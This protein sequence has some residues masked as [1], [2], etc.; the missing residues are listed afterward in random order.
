MSSPGFS[1]TIRS[2]LIATLVTGGFLLAPMVRHW[3]DRTRKSGRGAH[4]DPHVLVALRHAERFPRFI[5][6]PRPDGLSPTGGVR[7]S[8]PERGRRDRLVQTPFAWIEL[9]GAEDLLSRLPRDLRDHPGAEVET[10]AGR[11]TPGVNILQID[12]RSLKELGYGRI[13]SAIRSAGGRVLRAAPSRALIVRAD[14][15]QAL[16]ALGG[17]P[18]VEAAGAYRAAYKFSP[19]VGTRPL[20]SPERAGRRTM[21][22]H[23]QLWPGGDADQAA[24]RMKSVAGA[25]NVLRASLDGST[26][27]IRANRKQLIDLARLPAVAAIREAP[28]F[29][30]ANTEAPPTVM[31]G[32]VRDSLRFSRPYHDVGV[33][34]GGIDTNGDGRR[35]NDGSDA[36]P[37]QI[38]AVTD[39]GLSVD[40]TQFSQ[41][42]TQTITLANPIGPSHRKIHFI[43]NVADISLSACDAILSGATTHGNVVAGLIAGNPGELGFAY[44]KQIDPQEMPLV[45]NLSLDALARGARILMQDAASPG[46]CTLNEL[47]ENGGNVQPGFLIDRLTLAICPIGGGTG[48][49]EGVIG[50][51]EDLHLHVMPFGVPNFD[52]IVFN[53]ANGTYTLEA[54]QID[55]FLVN[56][57]DYMVFVPVGNQGNRPGEGRF[58]FSPTLWPDL[59]NGTAAD[60][61]PNLDIQPLQ[62]SPPATAKNIVSVGTT[63][64]DSGTFFEGEEDV[65]AYSAHGPAT[66]ASLRT[67]PIVMAQGDDFTGFFGAPYFQSI[68]VI[69][70]RDNDQN[71]PVQNEVDDQNFGTSFSAALATAA[72]ALVRDYFAQG[73]YP[74]AARD[75]ADRMP[76]ISGSLVRAAL[77]AS[78]NFSDSTNDFPVPERVQDTDRILA[79]TRAANLGT[80]AGIPVGIMGNG[81][82]GYG[83]I[84]LDQVLPL[85]NYPPTRGL[86][87]TGNQIEYPAPGLLVYDYLGTG[88]PPIDNSGNSVVEKMFRVDGVNAVM[89]GG[90]RA[91]ANGQLRI[92]LSWPDPPDPTGGGVLI[93]DL[94]LEVESPGPDNCLTAS[95]TKP[96]GSPCPANAAD[97]NRAYDGNVYISGRG[98][99]AGQWSLER[100]V[101]ET[102]IHDDKNNIEAVHLSSLVDDAT[103]NQLVAGTWRVRVK[104]GAAGV[105]PGQIVLID[106]SN[107]DTDGNGRLDPDEVDQDGDGLLD[108]GGQPFSLVVAG[109]VFGMGGQTWNGKTH[110]LPASIIAL[111]KFKYGCSDDLRT[112]VFDT[113]GTTGAGDVTSN[114]LLRVLDRSGAVQDEERLSF[115]AEGGGLFGT[116]RTPVRLARPAI[117]FNGIVEGDDDLALVVTYTDTP[118]SAVARAR[119]EC[120]PNIIRSEL[121]ILGITNPEAFIGGGC[122]GD[123]FLDAGER[124]TYSVAL[125]N[126]EQEDDFTE[127]VATLTPRGPGAAA[128]RVLDSPKP[129]GR[130][131]GGQSTGVTF[132]LEVDAGVVS[133]LSL[134]ERRVDLVLALEGGAQNLDLSRATYTFSHVINSDREVLHYSTDFPDGG[135]EIRDFNRNL[136]IDRADTFDPFKQL[137]WPDEAITFQSMFVPGTAT[138][139]IT[140]TLGEDLNDNGVLDAGEDVFANGALDRGILADSGGPSAGDLVP[141]SFDRNDGGWKA[142]RSPLSVPGGLGASPLWEHRTEGLCGFQTAAGL[143]GTLGIWHTGDGDPSTPGPQASACDNYR[144]PQD[145]STPPLAE[146]ILDVLHSPIIAKVHQIDDARG[147][148]FE[149]EFQRLGFNMNIQTLDYAGGHVDLDTDIE[150]DD[151]NCLLCNYTYGNFR[152]PDIY[153]LAVFNQYYQGI[154]PASLVNQRTF[155]PL[156]DPDGSILQNRTFDGDESGFSAFT[157]DSNPESTSPIP[158]APPDFHPFP[159]PGAPQVC[160]DACDPATDPGCECEQNTDAGPGR[161]FDLV[162]LEMRDGFI[163]MSLGGGQGEPMGAHDFGPVGNRWQIG[164]GFWAQ[165]T[166]AGGT[167]Y[168]IGIDDVVLE[169]DEVHPV[170]EGTDRA[171]DRFGG[172]GQPAG[173]QCATLVVDRLNIYECNDT[174]EV[175]VN[176]PNRAGQ[177]STTVLATT[178]SDGRPFSTG[179]TTALIPVKSFQ[180]PEV[181]NTGVFRGNVTIGTLFNNDN[182]LFTNPETDAVLNFFYIDPRCD[183]DADGQVGESEFGNI[184]NDGID[185]GDNCPLL[186]NPGQVDQDLDGAGDL[187]D[188]CPSVANPDQLDSD[189]DRVGDVCDLDDIDFDGVVNDLDNCPDVFNAGQ[190]PVAGQTTR[191]LACFQTSDRDGDGVNDRNDNCVRTPNADQSDTD[192]DRIGD[193]CDG[194]CVNARAEVLPTGSCNRTSDT[195]CTADA[196]CP[197][198]GTCAETPGQL[199]TSSTPQCTCENLS[200]ESCERLGVANDGGCGTVQDDVDGDSVTDAIDNCPTIPNPSPVPGTT[201]QSDLDSD[202]R[203]DECDPQG[204]VDD[205]NNGIP[206]DVISFN[207]VVACKKLPLASFVVLSTSVRDID[208]DGDLFADT[209]ETARMSL[210]VRNTGPDLTG[211]DLILGTEDPDISCITR[212]T[213]SVPALPSGAVLETA[214]LGEAGEFEF[215]VNPLTETINPANAERGT[216]FLTVSANEAVGTSSKVTVEILLD[217]DVAGGAP[218]PRVP[219]PDGLSGTSD[220]GF[221][222]ENFDTDREGNDG[223]VSLSSLPIGTPNSLNDTIGVTVGTAQGG[224]NSIDAVGC[225]GFLVPPEDP[226][227]RIDPDNDMDW[228]IHCPAGS[229]DGGALFV[230]PVGG[231]LAASAPNSLHWGVHFD[232]GNVNGDTVHHRELAAF[233]TNPINL[234]L[235]P[236]PGELELSFFM[237]ASMMDDRNVNDFPGQANDFGDVQI[238][239]DLNP[240]PG[241]END[242][243]GFWEKL[244]P[245]E[246]TYDHIAY[247]WSTFGTSPTY[248]NL[249]PTD[250][251]P[252]A[253]APRGIRETLCFPLGIWSACGNAY[254]DDPSFSVCDGTVTRQNVFGK[255]FFV[256]TKFSLANFLGQ[257]VRIRWIAQGWEFDCCSSSY[258]ETGGT[259]ADFPGDDGWWIDDIQLTGAIESQFTP[260]ADMDPPAQGACP[261]D[262]CDETAGDG[263]FLVD[264]AVSDFDGDGLFVAGEQAT[265]SA[266]GT[267]PVGGCVGGGTQ[268]RFFKGEVPVQDW[269]STPTFVDHPLRPTTYRAQ[270]RCSVDP[271][272]TSSASATGFNTASILVYSGDADEIALSALHDRS[273]GVTTIEWQSVFQPL[274]LTGY[275]V[276]A[277]PIDVSGDPALGTLSG[278]S[279]LAS[280]L[281]QPASAPGPLL[282][283]TDSATPT[284]GTATFFLVGY[285]HQ[286][287][288]GT[289]SLVGRRSD[290]TLRPEQPLCP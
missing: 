208:G 105:L 67:A 26:Y 4:E 133:G 161:N 224:I 172:A 55:R 51:G 285:A 199:C 232:Q 111:D 261:A 268:Y 231:E 200:Q 42:T 253:T 240:L 242:N 197:V 209:G 16:R 62:V 207:T 147:F 233:M 279:C 136:Q 251:G 17:L 146:K 15:P 3:A 12:A 47:R 77:V 189:G 152:F 121:D 68:A 220:D 66:A 212:S 180:I 195:V 284:L 37:P 165:E 69:R 140:N 63:F 151:V 88:E 163:Y 191:G 277:G 244:V 202:G 75:D 39:N 104:R 260:Q 127:V 219:G 2:I 169:W 7:P 206:D 217:L 125:L 243:W 194:D 109:P 124:V 34:G 112:T 94:D 205:D 241:P 120:T 116:T 257:R 130:V 203:G 118:R 155:G 201:R 235:F 178:G 9:S 58:D 29:V 27:L 211:V 128:I 275:D 135:R 70:S 132:S 255:G 95:D 154:S 5:A 87:A 283:V 192:N 247:I 143:P 150:D 141:W 40:S 110:A 45:E 290:G 270:V 160:V 20:L 82:Q 74:T 117:P 22:V 11:M 264:V 10:G 239:V 252:D 65:A 216:F 48:A 96:D 276:Y 287:P 185:E 269:S 6:E 107:E 19:G 282:T 238:Q 225:G 129:I 32:N 173:A 149:V 64:A 222:V 153:A 159:D 223:R 24:A 52:S 221:I 271:A 229:C 59:F 227:C 81:V 28:E 186:F 272:C 148:P 142:L 60:N 266:A 254:E 54:Q 259:W 170:D 198:T 145:L 56:N 157:Q 1:R 174:V 288:A 168:G 71:P 73:F 158:L 115:G 230:T 267:V 72:G 31:I 106:G 286:T 41:T 100:A 108:S 99:P 236:N 263:G 248:C 176:D 98:L 18:F 190:V 83:R 246:N 53:L 119:F 46:L 274:T 181:G 43:Q 76:S 256:Q 162:L 25:D 281:P 156:V 103:P 14:T 79:S 113:D 80:I 102:A 138:G 164:I 204:T 188:N 61:D 193:V 184:D 134:M 139:L 13:E 273:T 214:A 85:A 167:D 89:T 226:E 86:S 78:A 50:G 183:A 210:A 38:V 289:R 228:H 114:T 30:L 91:I 101:S 57:L 23:V 245:F 90:T 166:A 179:V 21:D 182:L 249:T 137:F 97:D 131:P 215:V 93:N 122:D 49:C 175:T 33:D 84:L 265:I 234:T 213:I 126:F 36:V 237:V 123:Q 187:C 35:I 278:V 177:G 171:C 92:A 218:P 262:A 250:A 196:E 44:S 280:R 144:L 258:F 8:L